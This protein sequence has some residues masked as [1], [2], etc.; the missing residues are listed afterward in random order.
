MFIPCPS[1]FLSGSLCI[2]LSRPL[3]F[4][5]LLPEGRWLTSSNL[6]CKVWCHR[7]CPRELG[8]KSHTERAGE[9]KRKSRDGEPVR[10]SRLLDP[11]D[12]ICLL[13]VAGILLVHC[14]QI[15][16]VLISVSLCQCFV[17]IP[18]KNP[19]YVSFWLWPWSLKWHF[20]VSILP[21]SQI[22]CH[23]LLLFFPFFK[24]N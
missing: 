21:F 10:K 23:P 14:Y 11:H 7:L 24:P 3:L 17:L 8:A 13:L 6:K 18:A 9:T 16:H 1:P 22:F 15:R 5:S 12:P 20:S 19:S 4:F 2:S